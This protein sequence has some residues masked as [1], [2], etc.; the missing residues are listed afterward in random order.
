MNRT[1]LF[2]D[3]EPHVLSSIRRQLATDYDVLTAESGPDALTKLADGPA[4]AAVVSD[5]RMPGMNGAQ[6]LQQVSAAYPSTTRMI[7]SGQSDLASTIEAVNEG[8]IFR[9]ITKP[10]DADNLRRHLEIAIEQHELIV[11]R[12]ELLE[13]TLQGLVKT[14]TDILGLTNPVA[15][16]RTQRVSHYVTAISEALHFEMPWQLRLAALLSQVGCV[17]L[18]P[19]VLDKVYRSQELTEDEKRQYAS[20]PA[21]AEQL[22]RRIPQLEP[23]ADMIGRQQQLAARDL[24][25]AFSDWDRDMTSAVILAA[26][27]ALDESL[28]VGY[29]PA[30]ALDRLSTTLPNLPAE[31]VDA[32]RSVH[33]RTRGMAVHYITASSLTLGMVVDQDVMSA[34]GDVLLARGD[35]VT[36]RHLARLQDEDIDSG[37]ANRERGPTLRVLMPA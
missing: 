26:A 36:K 16:Q 20:H 31:L 22:I 24:S 27:T 21:I 30:E 32:L 1:V 19:E 2:V 10:I 4:I 14:L 12:E 15:S 35:E 17:N 37:N 6:L 23:V 25:T 3:D 9:F 13:K 5:M 34:S 7:L 11:T 28:A 29:G 8:H 33:H 18:P